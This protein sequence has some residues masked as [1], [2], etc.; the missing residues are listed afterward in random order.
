[1]AYI[2]VKTIK[3]RQYRY[4]QRTYRQGGKVRTET[5][6]LGPVDGGRRRKGM[7]RRL[8]ELIEANVR[9]RR[10]G[11]PD[12][13]TMLRRYN[14]KVQREQDARDQK[15]RELYA[16]YGLKLNDGPP[17]PEADQVQQKAPSEEGA[18]EPN[19]PTPA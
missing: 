13:E 7:L 4:Q 9:T 6:Y 2:V 11:L 15:H 16:L 8:G 12:E 3:G 14:E 17:S 1:M 18:K 5:I 19:T 10:Y